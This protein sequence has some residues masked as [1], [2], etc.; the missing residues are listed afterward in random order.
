MLSLLPSIDF[1]ISAFATFRNV[2]YINLSFFW[3]NSFN[4]IPTITAGIFRF[5][6]ISDCMY[7]HSAIIYLGFSVCGAIERRC[8]Q[9]SPLR[10]LVIVVGKSWFSLCRI[11]S[12]NY[13]IYYF[14]IFA[15]GCSWKSR[16]EV[17]LVMSS[18]C[19]YQHSNT[20]RT[21]WIN[22]GEILSSNL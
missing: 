5:F 16:M 9:I 1:I 22:R 11:Q 3:S 17:I 2:P 15:F 8:D 21:L 14:V 18:S 6:R 12:L 7:L 10:V 20:L 13:G 4:L 19:W